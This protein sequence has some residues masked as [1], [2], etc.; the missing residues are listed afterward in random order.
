M[1]FKFVFGLTLMAFAVVAAADERWIGFSTERPFS[2]AQI[3]IGKTGAR[4]VEFDLVI[5]GT[6]IERI[7][8]DQGEF[9]RVEVPG[10]G[11]VGG[12]GEPMLPA[13]RRFV[14]IPRGA[15]A[16][17]TATVLD[18]TTL[19]FAPEGMPSLLYPV[20]RPI[21]KC[22]C[23]EARAWRFSYKPKAY[24]GLVDF[25]APQLSGPFGLRDHTMMMLTVAPAT[26]DAE[27]GTI[28][29]ATRLRVSLTIT[30]GDAAA[31]ARVK[32][33]LSSRHFDAFLSDAAINLNLT[34]AGG[35]A[36]PDS[37]PVEF[38]IVTPPQ[39]V[40]DLAPFVEWKTSTGYNVSLVTTDVTGTT[41]TAIKSYITGQ[42][43][44]AEPPV[45]IL[46]IGDSPSPLATY[47]PSG[48]GTGGSDPG[49]HPQVAPLQPLLL[50][51]L[52]W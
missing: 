34:D 41:T 39:F 46:M 45:Y 22:D 11:H 49:P 33:R 32:D 35:W 48:G 47:T 27:T 43:N 3:E 38:L 5:P 9:T 24:Q 7:S 15:T 52:P 50:P 40:V 25:G 13:L 20:Q 17:V 26:Y 36:Y 28:E 12:F 10:L 2:E 14:E 37:A 30:G 16:E 44:G 19:E 42:Y 21:P 4:L 1:R 8:S 51:R 6:T 18:Q 29:I 23:P 31:T